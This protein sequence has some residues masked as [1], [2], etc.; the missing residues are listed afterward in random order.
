MGSRCL[1]TESYS[2]GAIM[3]SPGGEFNSYKSKCLAILSAYI[4][5]IV[6]MNVVIDM[7]LYKVFFQTIANRNL[8]VVLENLQSLPLLQRHF[9]FQ[10]LVVL[11]GRIANCHIQNSVNIRIDIA[12]SFNILPRSWKLHYCI[13]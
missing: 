13:H 9:P 11:D 12:N 5:N 1:L 8:T 10:L 4:Y 3:D 7:N 2:C 6:S